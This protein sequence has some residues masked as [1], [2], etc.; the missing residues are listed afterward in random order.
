M[1]AMSVGARVVIER[2]QAGHADPLRGGRLFR[3][4]RAADA[5]RAARRRAARLPRRG[6]VGARRRCG[7]RRPGSAGWS[8]PWASRSTARARCRRARRPIRSAAS[9]PAAH[10]RQR[11]GAPIDLGV[12]A[13]NT[14]ITCCHGQR[15]GIFAGSGVGKSVLLSM[16]ARNVV[17]RRRGDRADRRARPRGAGV[18]AGRSRRGGPRPLGRGGGDLRRAGAD[19]PPGGLSRRWPSPNTSATRASTCCC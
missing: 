14:F 6:V 15:M 16:L 5:V 10:A 9:P 8:T 12:R 18:P 1:H 7:R 19:A 4:Q 2:G 11:V 17:G 13:L 3:R